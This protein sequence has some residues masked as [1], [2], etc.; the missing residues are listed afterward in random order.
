[1][2]KSIMQARRECYV[3]RMKYNVSTVDTLE[4]HHVLNGP[5]RQVA[6]QYGLKAWLCHRHHN[7]PGYSAHVDH[8]R[9]LCLKQQ[10]QRDFE[11]LYGHDRWMEVVGKNYLG[12][13]KCSM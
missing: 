10:A 12:G 13:R 3:C 5:L 11:T 6:E 9:R 2:S 7:E 1:M 8:H 4:E